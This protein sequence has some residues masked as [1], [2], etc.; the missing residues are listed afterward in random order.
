MHGTS[1]RTAERPTAD[2]ALP[3]NVGSD[4]EF[5]V[6]ELA[7][8]V[9]ELTGSASPVERRPLPGDDP[10]Q[11]Q[12]DLTRARATLGWSPTTPLRE[13]LGPTIAHFRA[14][15]AEDAAAGARTLED[16]AVPAG[17]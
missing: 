17:V 7:A 11:R 8:L 2:S 9:L 12:P 3:T 14:R 4:R 1:A 16:A 13:G 5:T 10:K 15:L 6:A